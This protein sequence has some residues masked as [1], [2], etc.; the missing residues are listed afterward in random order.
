MLV[1]LGPILAHTQLVGPSG[2]VNAVGISSDLGQGYLSSQ[3]VSNSSSHTN[4]SFVVRNGS[5]LELNSQRYQFT[6]ANCY[7]L[8]QKAADNSTRS[9]VTDALQAAKDLGLTVIRTWAFNDGPNSSFPLQT[10]PGQLDAQVFREGLDYVVS[11]AAAFGLKLILT[12]TNYYADYGGMQQYVTWANT[13]G[14]VQQFYTDSTIQAQ[15][16]DYVT[17]IIL[18]KN[19]F[20]GVVY[21][22]DPTIL[23]WDIANEPSNPGD[24]SGDILQSWLESASSYVKSV[25][26]NHLVYAGLSGLFGISTPDLIQI[27]SNITYNWLPYTSIPYDT[28][29]N[30]NDYARNIA[31]PDIDLASLHLYPAIRPHWTE[32]LRNQ[33]QAVLRVAQAAGKPLV[34][35]EFNIQRPIRHRNEGLQLIYGMLQNSSS[36]VAGSCI[37]MIASPT[38]PDYDGFQIFPTEAATALPQPGPGRSLQEQAAINAQNSYFRNFDALLSCVQRRNQQQPPQGPWPYL[39]GWNTTLSIIR[40]AAAAFNSSSAYK[41]GVTN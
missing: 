5:Q 10:Q 29:C 35:D 11:Q 1:L 21:R 25:D 28:A 16:R 31:T 18:R 8:M 6:G 20:T 37:W 38:Y 32:D 15:Y 33:V 39:D 27:N 24:D 26:S 4:T 14:T 40:S 23:A 41:I 3:Q 36:S 13:T 30:G 7:Y 2:T 19:T 12:L 17:A 34:V 22:D 9:Q